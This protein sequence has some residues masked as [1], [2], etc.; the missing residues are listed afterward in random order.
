[1]AVMV[2]WTLWFNRTPRRADFIDE[3]L[4]RGS[5]PDDWGLDVLIQAADR[6]GS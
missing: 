2:L 5:I 4:G 1:M 6:D 3:R